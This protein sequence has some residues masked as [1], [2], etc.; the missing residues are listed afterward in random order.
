[1]PVRWI[2]AEQW[3]RMDFPLSSSS[4]RTGMASSI[5][6]WTSRSGY[7]PFG[8]GSQT[9]SIP[10]AFVRSPYRSAPSLSFNNVTTCVQPIS[11]RN[12]KSSLRGRWNKARRPFPTWTKLTFKGDFISNLILLQY[13]LRVDLSAACAAR[14]RCASGIPRH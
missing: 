7:F 9:H 1:M 4:E 2:P 3:I 6:S 8:T 11:C 5:R 14:P 13:E 10:A 12:A